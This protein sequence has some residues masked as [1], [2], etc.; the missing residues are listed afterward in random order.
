MVQ[1]E[2]QGVEDSGIWSQTQVGIAWKT[3]LHN[4]YVASLFGF[5]IQ[6]EKPNS[7]T[8]E[9]YEK[10]WNKAWKGPTHWCSYKAACYAKTVLHM[11][12][13]ILDLAKWAEAA[14]LRVI[15]CDKG[16]KGPREI[17]DRARNIRKTISGRNNNMTLEAAHHAEGHCYILQMDNLLN[18][19]DQHGIHN[20][21]DIRIAYNGKETKTQ[22]PST[23]KLLYN[24]LLAQEDFTQ[25]DYI[26]KKI[27]KWDYI[28][29][30]KHKTAAAAGERITEKIALNYY[31]KN[32]SDVWRLLA[33]KYG[34]AALSALFDRW[35]T[36][37]RYQKAAS[38]LLCGEHL[39]DD[40]RH[41]ACCTTV[42]S[43]ISKYRKVEDHAGI[44]KFTLIHKF[45]NFNH[46]AWQCMFIHA[47]YEVTNQLRHHYQHLTPD[48]VHQALS[49]C[50]K[51]N[52]AKCP[53]LSI[54]LAGK[55][56]LR[57]R[58]TTCPYRARLQ[59]LAS[60]WRRPCRSGIIAF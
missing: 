23:Q 7:D 11:P 17:R 55:H 36:G 9:I 31:N 27:G 52:A 38:C 45:E 30:A 35:T 60:L 16:F 22:G 25:S 20:L 41:Y 14:Q 28:T 2:R 44:R 57:S 24:W 51:T 26:I 48:Q 53:A 56:T 4:T 5:L 32:Y 10:C 18:K 34:N 47:V 43:W 12:Y 33:P 42:K 46:L 1:D 6:L 37:K 13:E 15:F 49:N 19:L 40:L 8:M 54:V 59:R 3:R 29:D 50:M 21:D 58:G 39:G